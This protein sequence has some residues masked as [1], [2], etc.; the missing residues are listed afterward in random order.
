MPCQIRSSERLRPGRAPVV[1][2]YELLSKLGEG[3]MGAVWRAR[4]LKVGGREVA[5]APAAR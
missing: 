2:G 4:Q 3:G 1:A 5:L